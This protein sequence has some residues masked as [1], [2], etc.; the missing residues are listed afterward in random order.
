VVDGDEE[1]ALGGGP[2]QQG[3]G[4]G[5]DDEIQRRPEGVDLDVAPGPWV[6][7]QRAQQ[8]APGS[9]LPDPRPRPQEGRER[10]RVR[11]GDGDEAPDLLPPAEPLHPEARHQRA[12]AEAHDVDLIDP[13]L[14]PQRLGGAPYL[15]R[16]LRHAQAPIVGLQGDGSHRRPA[17]ALQAGLHRVE[18]L[19]RPHHAGHE[20]HRP[21]RAGWHGLGQL[22]RRA[23][24]RAPS[25]EP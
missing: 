23:L 19:R 18:V 8:P 6:G 4:G 22:K 10:A 1:G 7:R 9:H 25:Q 24:C 11:S 21:G 2:R 12:H 3:A 14:R 20:Q 13:R 15:Q 16:H 17:G 5:D